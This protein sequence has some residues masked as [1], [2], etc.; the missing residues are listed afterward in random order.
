LKKLF[1]GCFG[2]NN[3]YLIT[4][5]YDVMCSARANLLNSFRYLV[6]DQNHI[7][8]PTNFYE[9]LKQNALIRFESKL[10][11]SGVVLR[12]TT[13]PASREWRSGATPMN[14]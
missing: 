7:F 4:L 10:I 2:K 1:V 5:V 11:M 12:L 8:K 3:N 6:S 14:D 9:E 13:G